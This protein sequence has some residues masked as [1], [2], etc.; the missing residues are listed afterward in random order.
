MCCAHFPHG[1]PSWGGRGGGSAGGPGPRGHGGPSGSLLSPPGQ[2][3]YS[4]KLGKPYVTS[5]ELDSFFYSHFAESYLKPYNTHNRI[6]TDFLR[7]SCGTVCPIFLWE[8]MKLMFL[9]P[10]ALLDLRVWLLARKCFTS[11]VNKPQLFIIGC[12]EHKRLC[13]RTQN[14]FLVKREGEI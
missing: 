10:D 14:K 5:A 12:Y 3:F 13:K 2:D 8:S 1:W 9:L 7:C 6:T 11:P 4:V